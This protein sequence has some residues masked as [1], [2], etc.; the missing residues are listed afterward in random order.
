[1]GLTDKATPLE[2]L[3]MEFYDQYGQDAG[4]KAWNG[5]PMPLWNDCGEAVQNHWLAVAAFAVRVLNPDYLNAQ[6]EP[7]QSA[8][9][10]YAFKFNDRQMKEIEFATVYVRDFNHG[11]TGH[12][13]FNVI[14]SLVKLLDANKAKALP[15]D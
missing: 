5:S 10:R 8:D 15:L 14:A 1:M 6:H 4:W 12:N 3:A 11:A 2:N 7:P 9:W 13:T